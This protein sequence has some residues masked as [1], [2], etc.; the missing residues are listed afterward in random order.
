LGV[1]RTQKISISMLDVRYVFEHS[2]RGERGP[3]LLRYLLSHGADEFTITVM[4][5]QDTP[6]PFADAFEDQLAPFE[7]PAA[8]RRILTRATASDLGALVRLWSFN[9]TSLE[10]LLSFLDKGLFRWPAGP[11]G[12]L[13]DLTIYRRG[14]LVLGLVS[15]EQE[16]VLRLTHQEH[17][18]VGALDIPSEETAE[19]IGYEPP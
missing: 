9:D 13:E 15:H 14:E 8:E 2:L 11:D 10:R 7:R 1:R 5:L 18:E 17:I 19:W 6:A 12:W 3:R 4:T 16:G